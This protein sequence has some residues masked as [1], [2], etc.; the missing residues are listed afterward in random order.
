MSGVIAND[1]SRDNEPVSMG[2]TDNV[3]PDTV[4][5][6]E[7]TTE[8]V[9]VNT[10]TENGDGPTTENSP[11]PNPPETTT[12]TTPT[13]QPSP[14]G[15]DAE[16]VREF[17]GVVMFPYKAASSY[18][19]TTP[20]A[21]IDKT[22]IITLNDASTKPS[23]NKIKC[24]KNGAMAAGDPVPVSD[25]NAD[26]IQFLLMATMQNDLT[27]NDAKDTIDQMDKFVQDM[28]VKY[29]SV[30][31]DTIPPPKEPVEGTAPQGEGQGE[32]LVEAEGPVPVPAS[33]ETEG[34]VP[35]SVQA[36][37]QVQGQDLVQGEAPALVEA[38]GQGEGPVQATTVPVPAPAR[39]PILGRMKNWFSRSPKQTGGKNAS[40]KK[41]TRRRWK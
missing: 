28:R 14:S 17:T 30:P 1:F 7:P 12:E 40:N 10:T 20:N 22:L 35:A 18:A 37:D 11:K 24:G 23:F 21:N 26:I 6:V 38:E 31:V 25:I 15:F 33:V 41:Q 36:P 9:P 16:I 8:T 39:Q 27:K 29:P 4:S 13:L 34:P 3:V 19:C 2:Q 5:T 32:A